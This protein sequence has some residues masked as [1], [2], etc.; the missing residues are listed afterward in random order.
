MQFPLLVYKTWRHL[1]RRHPASHPFPH[2]FVHRF[3][4][5]PNRPTFFRVCEKV[6][7]RRRRLLSVKRCSKP[8]FKLKEKK[9]EHLF[10]AGEKSRC[11]VDH[12]ICR[13]NFGHFL[14]KRLWYSKPK[15]CNRLSFILTAWTKLT[16]RMT[17]LMNFPLNLA[18]VKQ[19]YCYFLLNLMI[20]NSPETN[21]LRPD[22]VFPNFLLH[23]IP[24]TYL[25]DNN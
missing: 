25:T 19:I 6:R 24:I 4:L 10:L 1:W 8:P 17:D 5:S 12:F 18:K 23:V 15:S 20:T 21:C 9:V 7:W 14:R 2:F 16:F 11:M 3:F 22:I 13:H